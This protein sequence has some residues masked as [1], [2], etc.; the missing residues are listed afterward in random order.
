MSQ[1][2]IYVG[3]L[4]YDVTS[5]DLQ[6]L[7]GE[8]GGLADV[9]LITDRETGRSKGFAFITFESDQ[10][11]QASLAADGTELKGRKM[12][13]NVAREDNR[14]SGGGAGGRGGAGGGRGGAGGGGRHQGAGGGG[15]RW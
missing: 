12:R 1:N 8:Y 13:V 9:K 7:F 3:N 14:S 11:V 2:K 5:D 6:D 10:G 15:N 4:S